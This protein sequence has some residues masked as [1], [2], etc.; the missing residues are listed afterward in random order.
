[1]KVVERFLQKSQRVDVVAIHLDDRERGFGPQLRGVPITPEHG[2]EPGRAFDGP[3]PLLNV[4]AIDLTTGQQ[5][6]DGPSA[7]RRP[8]T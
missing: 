3:L 1:V 5:R 8:L 7:C 6:G 2:N 4:I